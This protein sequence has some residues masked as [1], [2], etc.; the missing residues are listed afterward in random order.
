MAFNPFH[1]FRR[2]QKKM[3]AAL[4]IFCMFIFVL[5]SGMSGGD[6]FTM[7]GDWIA[8]RTSGPKPQASLYGKDV[9]PGT[10]AKTQA[11]RVI[12]SIRRE[13]F[14]LPSSARSGFN[15]VGNCNDEAT[16]VFG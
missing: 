9:E 4:T 1:G 10:V 6:W 12:A 13:I 16:S 8:G 2:H 3:F 5:Q 11:M 14:G 15:S 7:F